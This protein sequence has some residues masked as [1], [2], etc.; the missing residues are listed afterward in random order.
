MCWIIKKVLGYIRIE[1]SEIY[2]FFFIFYLILKFTWKNKC[3]IPRILWNRR[4]MWMSKDIKYNKDLSLSGLLLCRHLVS[5]GTHST[6]HT[7]PGP[8]VLLREPH[9]CLRQLPSPFPFLPATIRPVPPSSKIT[10]VL[11]LQ[12]SLQTQVSYINEIIKYKL[13]NLLS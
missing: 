11:L 2:Y 8:S 10:F 5:L 13:H 9:S 12:I 1:T 3:E 4:L 6:F 7:T